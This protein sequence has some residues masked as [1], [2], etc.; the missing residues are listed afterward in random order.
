ML[1][2]TFSLPIVVRI[3][4]ASR[5]SLR[6]IM[7]LAF[8]GALANV[9][10]AQSLDIA[11]PSPIRTNE[12]LGTIT[13]RDVGDAR[14]TD[15]F[16]AFIGTPGDVLITVDSNNLNGDVDIFTSSG[17]R[18][19]LKFTVYAGSSSPITKSIY[20]RTREDLI[21]RVEARTPNDDP[22]TYRIHFGGSFEPITGGPLLAETENQPATP[23]T[24]GTVNR[25][26]KKGRRVSSVGARIEEPAAPEV[27]AAPTPE[28]A[29]TKPADAGETKAASPKNTSANPRTRRSSARRTRGSQPEK[30]QESAAKNETEQPSEVSETETKPTPTR[31]RP[32]RRST[33]ARAAPPPTAP[34][35]EDSGP[36]LVIETSEGTLV[37]RY[38]STV[39]R[40][41]VE[42]GQVV[43]VGKD[44][45]IQRIPLANVLRMSI[46]P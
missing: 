20:L 39:R 25:T 1:T 10:G 14:L 2:K 12:V 32:T 11:S 8:I 37:D 41:T 33:T 29:E 38:M 30:K 26:G 19:L 46:S 16:Y 42:N 34:E 40:V 6:L 35:P 27:A 24:R 17:L 13:A 44:G 28:P 15:Y 9:A 22:G 18:P 5:C 31:R 45:K 3:R 4:K 7:L 23:A 21:L 43:V 36:R